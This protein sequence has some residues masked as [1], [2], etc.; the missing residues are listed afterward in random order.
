MAGA[1]SPGGLSDV[2]ANIEQQVMEWQMAHKSEYGS[3]LKL[4]AKD[5]EINLL[6]EY[7]TTNPPGITTNPPGFIQNTTRT[8]SIPSNKLYCSTY[9]P[10]TWTRLSEMEP[11]QF[12]IEVKG[13]RYEVHLR[14]LCAPMVKISE[15]AQIILYES[16]KCFLM[17]K[18]TH[19]IPDQNGHPIRLLEHVKWMNTIP[20]HDI[21][22]AIAEELRLLDEYSQ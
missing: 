19:Y 4:A 8:R 2:F 16:D 5:Y 15:D 9:D 18:V 7:I 10:E 12:D 6:R 1:L 22:R 21:Y 14:R 13:Q 20:I 17:G 11:T 3:Y